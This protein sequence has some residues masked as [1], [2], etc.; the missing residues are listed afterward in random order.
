MRHFSAAKHTRAVL[1][2][3]SSRKRNKARIAHWSAAGP[4]VPRHVLIRETL[5]TQSVQR[6]ASPASTETARTTA[7]AASSTAAAGGQSDL[8]EPAAHAPRPARDKSAS[9]FSGRRSKQPSWA[10]PRQRR[11]PR[12]KMQSRSARRRTD[13]AQRE[14]RDLEARSRSLAA[15]ASLGHEEASARRAWRSMVWLL[16]DTQIRTALANPVHTPIQGTL[17]L[18][19]H[20]PDNP[21]A[22]RRQARAGATDSER[23]RY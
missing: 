8:Q 23:T 10:S 2:F 9:A 6:A 15:D 19:S 5:K 3:N 13:A 21:G 20:P 7:A 18:T 4:D 11:R 22:I 16:S 1:G 12:R 17:D 14:R